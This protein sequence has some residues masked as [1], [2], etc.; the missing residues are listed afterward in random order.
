MVVSFV[1]VA[2]SFV[3]SVCEFKA[4]SIV[5]VVVVVVVAVIKVLFM[6]III[7][8]SSVQMFIIV[9]VAVIAFILLQVGVCKDF[10]SVCI[11][12][13]SRLDVISLS[14]NIAVRAHWFIGE[15][16]RI[17]AVVCIVRFLRLSI[18]IHTATMMS[19]Y[20]EKAIQT[21]LEKKRVF[22]EAEN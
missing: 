18:S 22:C 12:I 2:G 21:T 15:M 10:S 3:L 5:A 4:S 9:F 7:S 20:E 16:A 19:I 6:F 8:I 13:V 17:T 1:I 14:D 11:V